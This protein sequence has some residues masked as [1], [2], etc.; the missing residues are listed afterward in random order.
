LVDI[1]VTDE[2]LHVVFL[3]NPTVD[4][5]KSQGAPGPPARGQPLPKSNNHAFYPDPKVPFG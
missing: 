5:P 4:R 2:N 3:F 1:V